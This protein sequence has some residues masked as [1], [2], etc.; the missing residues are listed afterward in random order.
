MDIQ[1]K[2]TPF[3]R[4]GLPNTELKRS[5][6]GFYFESV[7]GSRCLLSSE[8][9]G[10]PSGDLGSARRSDRGCMVEDRVAFLPFSG[11][12]LYD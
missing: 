7:T 3:A 5:R 11:D 4:A 9:D 1:V 8:F 2:R 10:I 6:R 12:R